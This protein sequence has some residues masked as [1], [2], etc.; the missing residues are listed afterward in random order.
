MTVPVRPTDGAL[1]AVGLADTKVVF[2]GVLS[3]MMTFVAVDS[4][5]LL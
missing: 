1:V 4:P 2:V 3:L 5:L